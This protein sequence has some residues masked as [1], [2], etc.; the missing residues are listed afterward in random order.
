MSLPRRT[1]V[2]FYFAEGSRALFGWYH[3]P[4]GDVRP[5]GVVVCNPIGDDC[6][7]AHRALRHFAE[8]ASARGLPVL[9]FDFHGTGDSAGDERDAARVATWLDDIGHAVD[10]LRARSGCARIC[11][12]GLRL[13]ATLATMAAARRGDVERLILWSPYGDGAAYVRETTRLHQMHRM[14]EPDSFT[15]EPPGWDAGGQ[16]ALGF[17]LTHAT[18][19]ELREI[20][21]AQLSVAPARRALVVGSGHAGEALLAERLRRLGCAAEERQS[22]DQRFLMMVPHKA[23][24]PAATLD[25]MV[26]WLA[27]G[28]APALAAPEVAARAPLRRLDGAAFSEQP[29]CFGRDH[30]LFGILSSPRPSPSD[31]APPA[32]IL[33]NAGTVHRIGPHR[34][35]VALARRLSSLGFAV[36]RMDLSGIGDSRSAAGCPENLC[37]P[38]DMLDDVDRAMSLLSAQ[39]GA[40]RFVLAGLCSGGDIAFQTALADR[41][42]ASAV[43]INPR[44]FCVN[45]LERVES[46]KRARYWLDAFVDG[47]KILRLLRGQVDVGRALGL[48][49]A[50]VKRLVARPRLID[51]TGG[52]AEDVPASL[53]HLAE[54]GV[55]TLLVAAAHD[56]GVEYV[57]M[58]RPRQ[59]R[60]LGRLANFRRAD[61]HGTDH[62]FTSLFAQRLVTDVV[63]AHVAARYLP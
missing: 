38:R 45:D 10:E 13:G 50:N 24:L 48:L 62:T 8:R 31:P 46:Y 11:L 2:P 5:L 35:Y 4:V 19:G 9:R 12:A 3:P 63:V 60:A 43:L 59:M 32:V 40:E 39:R 15:V 52:R 29:L 42:V 49:L 47:R 20:D 37:Y 14:L 28:T 7:R 33:L 25:L 57:D 23:P 22:P 18:V 21:V 30:A 51:P 56:P 1:S 27:E 36:L 55:D 34:L 41:R 54:R 26:D 16:E 6:V 53:R 58:Q 44:T 17:L 61:L